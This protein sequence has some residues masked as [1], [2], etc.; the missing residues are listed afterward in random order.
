ME[1][2]KQLQELKEKQKNLERAKKGPDPQ[3]QNSPTKEDLKR[4]LFEMKQQ[5]EKVEGILNDFYD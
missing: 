1:N 4:K 5:L 2:A 3:V